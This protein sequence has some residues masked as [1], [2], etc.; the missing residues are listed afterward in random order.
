MTTSAS[1]L[2]DENAT[3]HLRDKDEVDA[4]FP[5]PSTVEAPR[6]R[7]R[8]RRVVT[9]KP[10]E[11]A[12]AIPEEKLERKK[13]ASKK[14][15]LSAEKLAR[16]LQG[17]HLIAAAALGPEMAIDEKEAEML[18]ESVVT[19]AKEY[20]IVPSGKAVAWTGFVTTVLMVYGPRM[21]VVMSKIKA[22][23]QARRTPSAPVMPLQ[24]VPNP[25]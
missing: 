19:L 23:T 18:A 3:D 15:P 14:T 17:V 11:E 9:E 5:N 22:M 10:L 4:P 6:K 8:K 7:G 20:D 24:P 25:S 2:Y 12:Q 13:R 1:H 16:Q 21:P